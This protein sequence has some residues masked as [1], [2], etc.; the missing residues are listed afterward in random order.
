MAAEYRNLSAFALTNAENGS[1]GPRPDF[2][3]ATEPIE[4]RA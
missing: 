1:Q 4:T 2:V 3:R